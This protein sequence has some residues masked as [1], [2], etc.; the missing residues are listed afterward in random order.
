[1][2]TL[3]HHKRV[4]RLDTPRLALAVARRCVAPAP[5]AGPA[6]FNAGIKPKKQGRKATKQ[7]VNTIVRRIQRFSVSRVG[8]GTQRPPE[9]QLPE[10]AKPTPTAPP[11]NLAASFRPAAPPHEHRGDITHNPSR[12]LS[13]TRKILLTRLDSYQN[14]KFA[15]LAQP[16][17]S[18]A[19]RPHHHHNSSLTVDHPFLRDKGRRDRPSHKCADGLPGPLVHESN[20]DRQIIVMWHSL[21]RSCVGLEPARSH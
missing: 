17:T 20:P 9:S 3:R 15:T 5:P 14:S 18:P 16:S 8:R 11:S 12:R 1:M 13:R 21:P 19:R 4:A 10:Y 6:Y 7:P 2:A